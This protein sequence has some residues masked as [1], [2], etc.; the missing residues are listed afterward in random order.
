METILVRLFTTQGR[1][2][3]QG[4]YGTSGYIHIKMKL[5]CMKNVRLVLD[6]RHKFGIAHKIV[7]YIAWKSK[8]K[9]IYETC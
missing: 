4:F 1:N 8:P 7:K 5:I 3:V 9:L 2:F 6:K